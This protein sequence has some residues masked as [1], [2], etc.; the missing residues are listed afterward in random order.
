[1]VILLVNYERGTV[2]ALVWIKRYNNVKA[3]VKVKKQV[4]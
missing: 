4:D 2:S 3:I 1:M